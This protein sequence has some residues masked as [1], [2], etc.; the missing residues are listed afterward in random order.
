MGKIFFL[1]N[2]FSL[3]QILKLRAEEKIFS[4]SRTDKHFSNFR[5]HSKVLCAPRKPVEIIFYGKRTK[6]F[7]AGK[8]FLP[9]EFFPLHLLYFQ[10]IAGKIKEK[11]FTN[12][13][14]LGSFSIRLKLKFWKVSSQSSRRNVS[15]FQQFFP[16]KWLKH[17]KE[18]QKR[19]LA[20]S[21]VVRIFNASLY[22]RRHFQDMKVF[23][24]LRR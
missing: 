5:F 2:H 4:L 6:T 7:P 23:L 13:N 17:T 12:Q 21:R 1:L 24:S 19:Q 3:K 9:N 20:A 18:M 15:L 11:F 10:W 16:C 22:S 8:F 14:S